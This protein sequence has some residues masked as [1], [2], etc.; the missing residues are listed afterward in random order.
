M[1][2]T[3]TRQPDEQ[4]I[5]ATQLQ[6]L[7]QTI[8]EKCG[9]TA[10]DA[11]LLA[12]SL[13][14]ADL[15]G[16]HSHGVLRVPE[17]VK[18][19][20]VGGVNPQGRP[21]IARDSGA[22]LVVDGG[23]SMGQI[24]AHFAMQKVIERA[25]T[26]GIAA[27]AIRGSNHCGALAYFAR[28]ALDQ[29][30]IGMATTNA[31]PTMAPWGGAERILGINPVAFA[32]PAGAE[33]PIV[34]DAAFS[35][36]AHGKI[37]VYQQKGLT[38]PEG[39][40][41]DREGRPTTDPAVALDGLLAPI[42]G[43]KGAGLALIMGILSSMLSGAAYGT[44]LGSL[45]AGPKPGEDGHFVAAIR[46]GA[47]EA[48]DRFKARVDQAVQQIHNVKLAPGFARTYAPGEVE[49][50]NR[51]LY[52]QQGIPLN[53]VTLADLRRTAEQMGLATTVL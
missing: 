33:L 12:D 20:T 50:S 53:A 23:N 34:Y 11:A 13:V 27:A 32:I 14:F 38:L 40:A 18:K 25:G 5:D 1:V 45:E 4:R 48:V 16:V 47:F 10:P 26:T 24:G 9:M 17:Y 2:M 15:S 29:E 8:F 21:F 22:C 49:W 46:V 44:E 30:M 28:M 3:T 39:W 7:V 19:L 31:L 35:G 41:L 52:Q 37:R 36:S 6:T 51:T 43:F 42:G